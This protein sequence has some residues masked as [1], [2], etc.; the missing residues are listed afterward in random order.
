MSSVNKQLAVCKSCK[1]IIGKL[2]LSDELAPLGM[3]EEVWE[4]DCPVCKLKEVSK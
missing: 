2:Q 1:R 4:K 3:K